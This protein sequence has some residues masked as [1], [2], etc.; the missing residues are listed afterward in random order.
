M[1]LYLNPNGIVTTNMAANL[2]EEENRKDR[3]MRGEGHPNIHMGIVM[4]IPDRFPLP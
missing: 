2:P 4:D 1:N 3:G